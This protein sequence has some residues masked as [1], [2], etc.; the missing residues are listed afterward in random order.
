[1]SLWRPQ[2][3]EL[4]L[5]DF[6][7]TTSALFREFDYEPLAAASLAQVHRA[8]LP[9]GTAVAVKVGSTAGRGGAG[10]HRGGIGGASRGH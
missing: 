9:D 10:G 3:D 8:T 2:V 6:Q 1:M 4:F 7:S 5:E